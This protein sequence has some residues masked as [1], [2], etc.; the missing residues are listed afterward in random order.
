MNDC[1]FC[2]IGAGQIKANVVYDDQRVMAFRDLNPKAPV[3][4]LIIPKKHIGSVMA[5]SESELGL[6]ADIYRAAQKVA[7]SEKLVETGF[8]LVANNGKDAGQSVDHLHIHLLG[9]R[10]LAWPPG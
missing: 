9:G 8:R 2:K 7:T 5:T 1:I 6:F 10:A 3:H 4:I